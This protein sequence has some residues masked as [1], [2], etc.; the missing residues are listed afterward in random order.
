MALT[1]LFIIINSK[2]VDTMKVFQVQ[3]FLIALQQKI[4]QILLNLVK[5]DEDYLLLH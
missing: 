1:P 5:H 4:E 2:H 3:V